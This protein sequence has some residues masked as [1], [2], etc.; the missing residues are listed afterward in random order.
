MTGDREEARPTPRP[1][2][3]LTVVVTRPRRQADPL[4]EALRDRGARVVE[5]PTI[6]IRPPDE[7]D[8]LR[9]A[10]EDL[11]AYD[12]AVFT[13][14]NGV[15]HVLEELEDLG[16]SPGTLGNARLAAIGP[17]T[18]GALE[19]AGLSVEVVPDEYRAEALAD[20]VRSAGPL[21]GSRMLLARAS[22]A[23][24]V[25]PDRLEAHGARVDEVTAY[26]TA[27][28]RPDGVDLE[29]RMRRDEVDW[30]T[31]TASST[32]RN[33]V[34]LAGTR[35]GSARVACIGPIT[36]RT[37][38]ELGLPVHAVADEYTVPGLVRAL[39]DAETRGRG[40]G[41]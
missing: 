2:D 18:A 25:L 9:R 4:S 12:W 11:G 31:F 23:R 21:E 26:E 20:A 37:A 33:F 41:G 15:R 10:L 8:P 13:S 28:G 36:A 19:E 30:I 34:R 32:V 7:A 24:D 6:R 22:E 39:V 1:L 14:V 35:L 29:R 3:G 16:R 38:R 17:S 5:Y 40:K 27:L